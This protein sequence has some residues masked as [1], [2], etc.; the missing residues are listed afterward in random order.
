MLIAAFLNLITFVTFAQFPQQGGNSGKGM[1]APPAIGVVFGKVV[2]S[3]NE[4][5]AGTSVILMVQKLDTTTGKLKE[6][7]FQAQTTKGNGNFRFEKVP[8]AGQLTLKISNTG[9]E[10]AEQK[11]MLLDMPK[12]GMPPQQMQAPRNGQMPDFSSM[13]FEKDLGS[14]A[15]KPAPTELQTVTITASKP[16]LKMDIDKKV[17]NVEKNIVSAGGTAVDVM[18]NVPSVMVDI[19]GNVTMRNA[20]PQIYVDGRPTTLSLDQIP[21]DAIESVEVITNPSAKFDASGGNAGILNIVLKKNKRNGYNGNINAGIDKRGGIN[22]GLNA[23]IRQDKFNFSVAGFTNQMKMRGTSETSVKN[24]VGNPLILVDQTGKSRNN[25]GF[26]FG[27]VGLD[28]FA[29]NLATFSFGAT[30]V[31]GSFKPNDL[32]FSDSTTSNGS[33]ISYSERDTKNNREFNAFGFQA[34]YKQ[35]FKKAGRELTADINI[36]SGKFEGDSKYLTT[37]YDKIGGTSMAAIEQQILSS[38]TNGFTTIQ[39][40]YVT[41]IKNGKIETGLRAQ[42]RKMDNRQGNYFKSPITGNLEAIPSA[43]SNYNN[44]DDVYAAYLSMTKTIKNFGYQLGLRAESSNYVGELTDTK[45][46]FNNKYPISLFPSVFLSQKLKIDQELQLNYSRRINRPFF[47]QIIPFIDSTDQLNWSVGNGALKPEFTSSLEASYTKKFKGGHSIL[48]SVYYKYTDNLITRFIDTISSS[49]GTKRPLN[50]YV[51]ANSSR[52]VGFEITSQNKMASWWDMNTNVNIYNSVVNSSN[53][54][55]VSQDALWSW[56]SKINNN[57]TLLKTWKLQLSAVYQSKTNLPV[58][59]GGFNMGGPPMGGSQSAAQGYIRS[60]WAAD[61]AISKSFL[62]NNA[63]T[64]T[65]SISDIFRTRRMSQYSISEF[66][67]QNSYRLGD[68]P[69]FRLNFS[70]RF[71]QMDLSILKRKNMKGEMEGQQGAMQGIQ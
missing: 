9:Y 68:V 54:G 5:L 59:Q 63:A 71:G 67:E 35:L 32:L 48:A 4:N 47:M 51:N 62:K 37:I 69:M 70:F 18:K 29:T 64:A 6:V 17:F 10:A 56:F 21:A 23:S 55:S 66:F 44:T 46:Q 11:F 38:G 22:G 13:S 45:Q 19:D 26:M 36:F 65:F 3:A 12:G 1:P 15:M 16:G 33:Q 49:N 34:G 24:L 20:S 7:L 61:A 8:I 58:N 52:A 31:R 42:L 28:Y 53:L 27:R 43:S 25:G 2:G 30:R 60:N 39:T 14:I 40:D 57:F 50:T 41:P